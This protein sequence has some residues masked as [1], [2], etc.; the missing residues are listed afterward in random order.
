MGFDVEQITVSAV[1]NSDNATIS[2]LDGDNSAVDDASDSIEGHQVSLKAGRNVFRVRV[3]AEDTTTTQ[4]YTVI[5][6]RAKPVVS[7]STTFR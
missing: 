6:V 2:I 7:I 1:K 3:T 4:I 5:V